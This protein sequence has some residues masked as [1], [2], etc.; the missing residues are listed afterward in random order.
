MYAI[1]KAVWRRL[2]RQQSA[3]LLADEGMRADRELPDWDFDKINNT[4]ITPPNNSYILNQTQHLIYHF[5]E[6]AFPIPISPQKFVSR[7]FSTDD[8]KTIFQHKQVDKKK[9]QN[10]FL[11]FLLDVATVSS[12]LY[13]TFKFKVN[14]QFPPRTRH[15]NEAESCTNVWFHP[16]LIA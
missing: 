11:I 14:L 1:I 7:H 2:H 15:F 5:L 13:H 6:G 16:P 8:Y 3:V 4:W 9:P 12:L 10:S